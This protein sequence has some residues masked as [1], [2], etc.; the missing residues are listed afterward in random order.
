[1]LTAV[2]M[3]L[4]HDPARDA[5]AAGNSARP[6]PAK[7]GAGAEPAPGIRQVGPVTGRADGVAA[8]VGAPA[9][10]GGSAPQ[11]LGADGRDGR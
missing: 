3:A 6:A 5:F 8:G 4:V 2:R 7:A 11:R 1:M 9:S 10:R